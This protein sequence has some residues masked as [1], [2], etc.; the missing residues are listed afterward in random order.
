MKREEW[1]TF[2]K[3]DLANTS[4]KWRCLF[5]PDFFTLPKNIDYEITF[6]DCDVYIE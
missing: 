2:G 5:S 4:C 6:F 3:L 1:S